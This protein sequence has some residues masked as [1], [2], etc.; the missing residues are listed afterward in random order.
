MLE[1]T[2]LDQ[3]LAL[4]LGDER[5]Q[6]GGREGIDKASLGDDQQENLGTRKNGQLV[7]LGKKW[8][9]R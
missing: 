7:G 1:A 4:G 8:N 3:V 6:L 9:V 2:Y 5:L